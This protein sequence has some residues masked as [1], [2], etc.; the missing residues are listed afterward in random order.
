MNTKTPGHT[1]KT[2]LQDLDYSNIKYQASKI[3]S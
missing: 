2:S 1:N 3:I